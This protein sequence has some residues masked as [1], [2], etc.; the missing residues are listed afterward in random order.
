MEY[1]ELVRYFSSD[2]DSIN[3]KPSSFLGSSIEDSDSEINN[4]KKSEYFNSG[5][6]KKLNFY[7][8]NTSVLEI[9][10]NYN[11]EDILDIFSDSDSENDSKCSEFSDNSSFNWGNSDK[12]FTIF[13]ETQIQ[14]TLDN[15]KKELYHELSIHNEENNIIKDIQVINDFHNSGYGDVNYDMNNFFSD[16]IHRLIDIDNSGEG[17][18]SINS[19]KN[20][21][22]ESNIDE[23]SQY[24]DTNN[25]Q[26]NTSH[27][28]KHKHQLIKLSVLSKISISSN[29]NTNP[30][31]IGNSDSNTNSILNNNNASNTTNNLSYNDINKKNNTLIDNNNSNK[32]NDN[33][34]NKEEIQNE[35]YKDN[36]N[37]T[38]KEEMQSKKYENNNNA[39]NKKSHNENQ[40]Q[41]YFKPHPPQEKHKIFRCR[42]DN[43]KN[44]NNSVKTS[45]FRQHTFSSPIKADHSLI[46]IPIANSNSLDETSILPENKKNLETMII[47]MNNKSKKSK[48][49]VMKD[50][51]EEED[52]DD[53]IVE[54][55]N[56]LND[57][58]K[59]K[60]IKNFVISFDD[61]DSSDDNDDDDSYKRDNTENQNMKN[62][63]SFNDNENKNINR[64]SKM[65]H[66]FEREK[67]QNQYNLLNNFDENY[68]S[69]YLS[70]SYFDWLNKDV[71][72]FIQHCKNRT[73][74]LIQSYNEYNIPLNNKNNNRWA[75]FCY[76][77]ILK[78]D[79]GSKSEDNKI[80][81]Y[82]IVDSNQLS[83][84]NSING[85][86]KY[87]IEQENNIK[88]HILLKNYLEKNT[89]SLVIDDYS[90]FQYFAIYYSQ[91]PINSDLDQNIFL[92]TSSTQTNYSHE[93]ENCSLKK[94]FINS[95]LKNYESI[96]N[97]INT[98]ADNNYV[99]FIQWNNE[100]NNYKNQ[101]ITANV[102]DITIQF[103]DFNFFIYEWNVNLNYFKNKDS[104]KISFLE[105]T[106][107]HVENSLV[108]SGSFDCSEPQ[109]F[110]KPSMSY[111]NDLNEE[112]F[113]ENEIDENI[114]Y[115]E[116][117]IL[118]GLDTDPDNEIKMDIDNNNN[119]N[120]IQSD[121]LRNH[122]LYDNE[123][124]T[125][126][127]KI[128]CSSSEYHNEDNNDDIYE[129]SIILSGNKSKEQED[130]YKTDSLTNDSNT[131]KF[132]SDNNSYSGKNNNRHY[133]VDNCESYNRY[134]ESYISRIEPSVPIPTPN[135]SVSSF[136]LE[137]EDNEIKE[138]H[139]IKNTKQQ[140]NMSIFQSF[141][142]V[143]FKDIWKKTI[144]L[145]KSLVSYLI[146]EDLLI[147]SSKSHDKSVSQ[148]S[149][150]YILNYES[151]GSSSNNIIYF[152]E[153]PSRSQVKENQSIDNNHIQLNDDDKSDILKI[154]QIYSLDVDDD[155]LFYSKIPKRW[156]R[157]IKNS[158]DNTKKNVH[159]NKLLKGYH[160]YL[161]KYYKYMF[162]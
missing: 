42:S 92:K 103:M 71:Y 33:N 73:P 136:S 68:Y 16:Y 61:S 129:N 48:N 141:R 10:D 56:K 161:N 156:K 65:N 9:E 25:K 76:P 106:S 140:E 159:K 127:C 55:F 34:I 109:L 86:L 118:L 160:L 12:D 115:L 50:M 114:E 81:I 146:E 151:D 95:S 22:F 80:N 7:E 58:E 110:L 35:K 117:K 45:F 157:I 37:T 77:A 3:I 75:L 147:K 23:R 130:D 132:C 131:T 1:E 38:N 143:L 108:D 90:S 29:L 24:L 155:Y 104:S 158:I 94:S 57:P 20:D 60:S 6:N 123:N 17:R 149:H 2:E 93:S 51:E 122:N 72:D 53:E 43:P 99:T 4:S 98:T 135:T 125:T 87:L 49:K 74:Q 14:N 89:S 83:I 85:L 54:F 41:V 113:E 148:R 97:D 84:D 44:D 139:Y 79:I 121:D 31:D 15:I 112:I 144:P 64:E 21:R 111:W 96:P 91:K 11:G 36:D 32:D 39:N 124:V 63:L 67:L 133:N 162:R 40:E 137:K 70:I 5:K 150:I 105:S 26:N 116:S 142:D 101:Y 52:D 78:D 102:M 119:K 100:F 62:E 69:D 19:L 154:D 120:K 30:N 18:N 126:K 134:D 8:F 128:N 88:S 145:L 138:Y 66:Y 107:N 28:C 47:K 13:S 153:N 82:N 59:S 152:S 27:I 46:P